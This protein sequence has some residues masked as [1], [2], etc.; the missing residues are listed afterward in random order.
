M[1]LTAQIG[2]APAAAKRRLEL[3]PRSTSVAVEGKGRPFRSTIRA[4]DLRPI[5]VKTAT[6]TSTIRTRKKNFE[7]D[8]PTHKHK[9]KKN[10]QNQQQHCRTSAQTSFEVATGPC[11]R[12]R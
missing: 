3:R 10:E 11:I 5:L 6:A 12:P 1:A 4:P 7:K 2:A 9:G 8:D